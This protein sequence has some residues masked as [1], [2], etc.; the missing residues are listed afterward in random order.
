MYIDV[1]A[2]FIV[3]QKQNSHSTVR[4]NHVTVAVALHTYL[5]Q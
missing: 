3:E 4:L 1:L 5:Q 2:V